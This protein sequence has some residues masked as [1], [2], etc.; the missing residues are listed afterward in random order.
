VHWR[1]LLQIVSPLLNTTYG[2]QLLLRLP[3]R[4]SIQIP[5][6]ILPLQLRTTQLGLPIRPISAAPLPP[7]FCPTP[8][9]TL[10][11]AMKMEMEMGMAGGAAAALK[12]RWAKRMMIQQR[13]SSAVLLLWLLPPLLPRLTPPVA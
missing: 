9:H 2:R 3:L 11:T 8:D 6:P 10:V 4:P 7:T 1:R 5:I 13:T 12:A